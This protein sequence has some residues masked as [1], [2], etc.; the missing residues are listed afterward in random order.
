MDETIYKN[1]GAL[2][3]YMC[4][5]CSYNDTM[6]NRASRKLEYSV[7]LSR[8]YFLNDSQ[9]FSNILAIIQLQH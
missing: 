8:L 5:L 1:D 7:Q 3:I 9:H 2:A 4:F 6:Q